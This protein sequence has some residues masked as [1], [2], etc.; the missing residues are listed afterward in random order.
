MYEYTACGKPIIATRLP[1]IIREFGENN[2]VVYV[3]RPEDVLLKAIELSKSTESTKK[4]RLKASQYGLE[5]S[6]ENITD[7]FETM[8]RK[9]MKH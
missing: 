3:N 7:Q 2:N 5:H 6:W 9:L 4:I 8:L 1:G